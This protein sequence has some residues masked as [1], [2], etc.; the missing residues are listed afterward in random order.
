MYGKYPS[1]VTAHAD[2]E[3]AVEGVI[4]GAFNYGG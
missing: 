4:K 1:I 2:L 3:K